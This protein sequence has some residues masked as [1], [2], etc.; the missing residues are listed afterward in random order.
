MKTH[1]T[2]D[3]MVTHSVK[4]G[5]PTLHEGHP[6]YYK[7]PKQWRMNMKHTAMIGGGMRKVPTVRAIEACRI[8]EASEALV[9]MKNRGVEDG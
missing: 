1:R 8:I 6:D 9:A 3:H 5:L 7:A 4:P 2:D